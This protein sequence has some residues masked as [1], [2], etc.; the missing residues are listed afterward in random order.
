MTTIDKPAPVAVDEAQP[1]GFT[2]LQEFRR[3][4]WAQIL[5]S[6]ALNQTSLVMA[7]RVCKSWFPQ[8]A[9]ECRRGQD[10]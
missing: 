7:Q 1:T 4:R 6:N 9:C 3:R 10:N 5:C 2:A 8:C